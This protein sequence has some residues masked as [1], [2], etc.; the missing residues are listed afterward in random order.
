MKMTF[1]LVFATQEANFIRK[2]NLVWTVL[3]IK[4]KNS[5]LKKTQDIIGKNKE[6][7]SLNKEI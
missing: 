6:I 3:L 7:L 4:V 5:L 2:S 1:D